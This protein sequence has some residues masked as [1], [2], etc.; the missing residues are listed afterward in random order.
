MIKKEVIFEYLKTVGITLFAV[1]LLVLILLGVIQHKVYDQQDAEIAKDEAVE[2]YLVGVMIEKNKY[3]Q[4]ERPKDYR[5]NLK[6]GILYEISKDYKNSEAQYKLAIA[7]APYEEFKPQYKLASLYVRLDRL[8]DAQKVMD[9]I[10]EKPI[11]KLIDY[12]AEIYYKLG[13][14]FYNKGDYANAIVKYEKSLSYYQAIQSPKCQNIEHSI[15][16]AYVYLADNYVS[17]MQIEDAINALTIANSIVKAPILKYKLALLLAPTAPVTA[18]NYFEEVFR[19]EPSLINFEEYYGFLHQLSDDARARDNT[20]LADLYLYK[21]KNFKEYYENNVLS[22]QDISVEYVDGEMFLNRWTQ[23]YTINLELKLKNSSSKDL[24]SLYLEILFKDGDTVFDKYFQQVINPDQP[25][26]AGGLSPLIN[27]KMTKNKEQD[28]NP[29]KKI[30]AEISASKTENSYKL[31]IASVD[32][33]QV[34]KSKKHRFSFINWL[35]DIKRAWLKF[36]LRHEK[37]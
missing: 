17:N 12:K 14:K 18:Y 10:S 4:A 9:A 3:L 29:Q 26:A 5:I 30:T 35:D 11:K 27:I 19:K 25:L 6:L 23:K 28:D 20:A 33:K 32:I 37:S 8:D 16:S 13:E 24:K 22:V 1:F 2:Y 7:K 31:A 36:Y 21:A 15:A 34:A